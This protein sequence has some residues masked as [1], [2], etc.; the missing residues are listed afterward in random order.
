MH[1]PTTITTSYGQVVVGDTYT[2]Y[3]LGNHEVLS[4]DPEWISGE[5]TI[6]LNFATWSI[7][8]DAE[9]DCKVV[10]IQNVLFPMEV[11]H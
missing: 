2:H 4:I 11:S 3:M 10:R 7:F 6:T 9:D 1:Q 5:L 8:A